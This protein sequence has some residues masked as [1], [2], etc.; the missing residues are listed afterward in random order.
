M[1]SLLLSIILL[2]PAL[3]MADPQAPVQT[4][5]ATSCNL[6]VSRP[7]SFFSAEEY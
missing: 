2:L 6:Q 4:N 7:S 3:A 1:K 5:L